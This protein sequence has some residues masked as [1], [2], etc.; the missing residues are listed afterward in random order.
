ME[1]KFMQRTKLCDRI[2]PDY[3]HGEEVFNTVSHITGAALGVVAL[4][5][6][7]LLAV[8][9]NSV[10]SVVGSAVYGASLIVLYTMSSVYHGLRPNMAKKVMQIIDHCTIYFL[11][12]GSYTPI[13]LCAV[14]RVS[15]A[16]AWTLFGIVW[17]VSLI[18]ATF[19]AID[20]EKYNKLS[21]ACY[22]G[23]GWCIV[24]AFKPTMQAI[25]FTGVMLLLAG[26]IAYTVGAV[27][28]AL[29]E[30]I[31]YMH[32]VFHVFVVLG[33]ILQFFC[34]FFYVI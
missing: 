33:S 25:D 19:T 8:S 15:P 20:L 21:Q 13:L 3:T 18:A 11:I 4:I 27:L 17:G 12:A 1:V 26:G 2:L 6:C 31:R 16:Y 22:I 7:L 34:I 14:R 5:L 10:Y 28:Y 29:G 24:I 30:K 9:H 32:S 23:L